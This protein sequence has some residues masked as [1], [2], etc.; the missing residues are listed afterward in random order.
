VQK[1]TEKNKKYKLQ[2][3]SD[4]R[5]IRND[6]QHIEDKETELFELREKVLVYES[7]VYGLVEAMR[8][9]KDL[10]IQLSLRDK[11]LSEDTLRINDY[12]MQANEFI[13]EN[14]EFR[15]RLGLDVK[16]TIDLSNIRSLKSLELE[17]SKALNITLQG[18]IDQLEEE[19]LT[20]KS[21][22][23]LQAIEVIPAYILILI[24]G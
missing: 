9:I 14:Q 3:R 7:G 20:L 11:E 6:D 18:E 19:R 12:E 8:E 22:L 23:R 16:T 10:K 15:K 4:S 24:A 13:D 2:R 17:Q 1:L 5:R 21:G